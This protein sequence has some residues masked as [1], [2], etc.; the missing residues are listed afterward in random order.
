MR[1]LALLIIAIAA[2]GTLAP[3]QAPDPADEA[4]SC[5]VC[6]DNRD[7]A[8]RTSGGGLRSLFVDPARFYES[9]HADIGCAGCHG[10]VGS[11]P[12]AAVTPPTLSETEA[13]ILA[14]RP[15][16][17]QVAIASCMRCHEEEGRQFTESIHAT[18]AMA[19]PTGD[20]PL[21][22]D[23]HT[24]HYVNP[25]DDLESPVNPGNVVQTCAS[26]HA[27][28]T[29]MALHDVRT[30]VVT[31]FETSFHGAKGQLGQASAAVCTSCHG[32]HEIRAADDPRSMV[33]PANVATACGQPGCHPGATPRF[34]A[35]FTHELPERPLGGLVHLV[36]VLYTIAIFA[37]IGIML[38][39]VL[40][41][42][43]RRRQMRK[44]H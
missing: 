39:L 34:A 11:G 1:R 41:D 12:H 43:R 5:L 14:G 18:S 24:A 25:T 40:L 38:L 19:N 27:D 22:G 29:T 20:Q 42:F 31:T 44:G 4:A 7:F 23:C 33:N 9:T 10:S 28:A 26:C 36:Q 8:V 37:T 21:C 30:D 15:P 6:H 13:K 35:A 17:Q 2:T 16:I 3:G 32:V